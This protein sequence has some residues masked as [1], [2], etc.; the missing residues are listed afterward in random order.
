MLGVFLLTTLSSCCHRSSQR[1][2]KGEN[3][4]LFRRASVVEPDGSGNLE[5]E[6]DFGW[7]TDDDFDDAITIRTKKKAAVK[8]RSFQ[9]TNLVDDDW[10]DLPYKPAEAAALKIDLDSIEVRDIRTV[11]YSFHVRPVRRYE[12][13]GKPP[14]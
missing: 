14:F 13:K 7:M 10:A 1:G 6:T 9:S 3:V 12:R 11:E 8:G 5:F 4:V 2:G